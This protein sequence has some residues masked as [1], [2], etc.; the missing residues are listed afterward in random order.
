[1]WSRVRDFV[2]GKEKQ[3]Y[4]LV[5]LHRLSIKHT[6]KMPL[7]DNRKIINKTFINDKWAK[8]LDNGKTFEPSKT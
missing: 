6:R 3:M 5:G 8:T 2:E 1:M 4:D 7:G